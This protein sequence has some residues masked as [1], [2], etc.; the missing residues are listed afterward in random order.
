[1]K[2]IITALAILALAGTNAYANTQHAPEQ[3]TAVNLGTANSF[4]VL[5][6]SGITNVSA[7]TGITFN[8]GSSPTPT[9]TGLTQSQV[10]G[11]LYLSAN[12]ATAQAQTDLTTAYNDAAAAPCGTDLTGMD[13]GGMTLVPG[14]YCFSSSAQLTGK[15]T[16]DAQGVKGSQWIFQI[17]STLTTA[18]GSSVVLIHETNNQSPQVL[19]PWEQ[20]RRGCNIYW[21]IGSS[22]TDRLRQRFPG[23]TDG[24]H[25]HHAEWR[26]LSWQ[27]AGP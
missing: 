10:A 8:V 13:L 4:G 3:E 12:P 20:G 25:Q 17:G 11:T 16:L 1:M 7:E 24:A 26:P 27:G 2:G 9:V 21:Q 22:S 23:D 19:P 5:A 6:G 15:L 14:V 18:S